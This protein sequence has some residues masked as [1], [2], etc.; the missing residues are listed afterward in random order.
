MGLIPISRQKGSWFTVSHV[1]SRMP[2]CSLHLNFIR[3]RSGWGR[4][5]SVG[6]GGGGVVEQSVGHHFGAMLQEGRDAPG[7]QTTFAPP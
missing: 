4:G 5:H 3:V 6:V 1:Q 7:D 2:L